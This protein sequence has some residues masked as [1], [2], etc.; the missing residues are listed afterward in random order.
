MFLKIWQNS[1]ENTCARVSF[2][3][4]LQAWS[5]QLYLKKYSGAN[6]FLWILRKFQE[7][8]FYRTPPW[9]L[10]LLVCCRWWNDLNLVWSCRWWNDLNLVLWTDRIFWISKFVWYHIFQSSTDVIINFKNAL[11]RL[12]SENKLV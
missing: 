3:I 11:I 7:H 10:L 6:V 8:I 1:Q 4:K 2:L 12:V 9:P 5:L